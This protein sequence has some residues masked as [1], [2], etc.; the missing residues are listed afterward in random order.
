MADKPSDSLK[1]T[2]IGVALALLS[3]GIG[4]LTVVFTRLIIHETEP[5]SLVML[6]YAI[7]A[8]FMY[9]LA[10][11]TRR[12]LKF[13]R[14][15][16]LAMAVLGLLMFGAF[17]FFMARALEDT[18]AAR[19]GLLFATMPVITIVLGALFKVER[20]TLLKISGVLLATLGA[21][22]ALGERA[23]TAA[24]NALRGDLYMFAGIFCSSTFNVFAQPY[25][26]RYGS[27]AV[28]VYTMIAGVIGLT[29]MGVIFA[30]PFSGGLDFGLDV[31]RVVL[32]LAIP[33]GTLMIWSWGRALQLISP[34]QAAVTV[35]F[36]PLTAILAGAWVL[37]E[38]LSVRLFAGFALIVA[39]VVLTA[40]YKKTPVLP[41]GG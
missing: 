12:S 26:K 28:L 39:G 16:L 13:Q 6:R 30:N 9:L 21:A 27:V 37:S 11:V 23:G 38:P 3:T 1:I 20:M 19:G 33:G 34:T 10:V 35:G 18:T 32:L 15:D 24:P 36:N 5:L 14:G 25:L 8:L 31:W 41:P 22:L 29:I 17:P 7:A 4:G 2:I 40:W